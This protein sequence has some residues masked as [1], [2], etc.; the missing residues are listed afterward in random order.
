MAA[1]PSGNWADLRVRL[2]SAAFLSLIGVAG[3]VLGGLWFQ[4]LVTACIG[5]IV[6]EIWTMISPEQSGSGSIIAVLGAATVFQ[7]GGLPTPI[8]LALL[9]T[10]PVI[11][12]ALIRRHA[13][14]FAVYSF[15]C[16]LAGWSLISF[17]AYPDGTGLL[18]VVLL[19]AIVVASD[20]AGYFAGRRFGGPKFWPAVSP[21]KTWAGTIAGWI[22]AALIGFALILWGWASWIVMPAVVLIAFAGQMGDIAQSALKR[23]LG[24]KDSS[25]LIPGHGGFF[26]RFDALIGAALMMFVFSLIGN[27][28]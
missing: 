10:A 27:G 26:D 20:T 23:K 5:I 22:G 13:I 2:I 9:L 11:G 28:F 4:L 3:I 1:A 12:A 16:L 8:A 7:T 6:W 19:V 18:L 17:R 21:R 14:V 24:V 15:S 25:N